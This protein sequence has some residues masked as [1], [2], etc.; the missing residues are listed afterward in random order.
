MDHT[1]LSR[2]SRKPGVCGAAPLADLAALRA[3]RRVR[4][5]TEPG[6]EDLVVRDTVPPR[7]HVGQRVR[8]GQAEQLTHDQRGDQPG[9]VAPEGAV[10]QRTVAL[11]DQPGDQTRKPQRHAGVG[12]ALAVH[13]GHLR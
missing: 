7:P 9:A 8:T 11:A 4:A 2:S 1:A 10:D 5:G 13:S 6:G 12:E 3:V